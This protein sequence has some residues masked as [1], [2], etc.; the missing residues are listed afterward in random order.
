V[1]ETGGTTSILLMRV[2]EERQGVLGLHLAGVGDEKF[3]SLSIRF[4]GINN[5][6][7]SRYLL[8]CYFSV[9][10]LVPDALGVLENVKV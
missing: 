8:T 9:T 7:V 4:M 10:V 1:T 2:G 6:G 5:Q 3:Q